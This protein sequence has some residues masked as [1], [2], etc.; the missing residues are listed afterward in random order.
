MWG[1]QAVVHSDAFGNVLKINGTVTQNISLV[2]HQDNGTSTNTQARDTA[3]SGA[4]PASVGAGQSIDEVLEAIVAQGLQ[5][6]GLTGKNVEVSDKYAE[7]VIY[8]DNNDNAMLSYNVGFYYQSDEGDVGKPVYFVEPET[9]KVYFQYDDLQHYQASGPGGNLKTGRY[10]YGSNGL[11]YLD[12]TESNGICTMDN[13]K[14]KTVDLNHGH[15]G[16]DA[17]SF[18]CPTNTH[19]EIN[20]AYS[21]LND[22]H[23]FGV[24]VYDMYSNWYNTAPVPSQLIIR[25][26]YS[27]NHENAFWNGSSA[28]FGD[29]YNRYHPLVGLDVVS[30]EVAHGFTD[31]NSDLIYSGQSGG[32]NEAF[33]DIAGEAAEYFLRGSTDWLVGGDI[34]KGEG[35]ARYFDDPTRDGR[36][37][38]HADNYSDGLNVHYSSGVFNHAF[39]QLANLPNWN[40]RKAFDVFVDANQN[41]WTPSTNFQQGACD[42]LNAADDR[43]YDIT[44]VDL[45]FGVV[46]LYCEN[47]PTRDSDG[48][49]LPDIWEYR[50]GLNHNDATDATL[51]TDNDGI[52]N[53]SEYQLGTFPNDADS[54]DDGLDD[55]D[56]LN[57]HHTNPAIADT[58]SDGLLDGLEINTYNTDPFDSDT[59]D[60]GM[61]DGFEAL[62]GL[63]PHADDSSGDFDGDGLINIEEQQR[64]SNPSVV[65]VIKIDSKDTRRRPVP[66]D[67]F[68]N[69]SYSPDI[70]DETQN[71]SQTIPHVTV[72]ASHYGST[73]IYSFHISGA[74]VKGIFDIDRGDDGSGNFDSDIVIRGDKLDHFIR[75]E[76]SFT[77]SGQGGSISWRD[78]Y[79][80]YTFME[81]GLY[82]ISVNNHGRGRG[83]YNYLLHVSLTLHD[84][85]GDGIGDAWEQQYGLDPNNPADAQLDTDSD[86]LVNLRE[87]QYITSPIDPDSDDDGLKD[88][89]EYDV[90]FTY[91][92]KPDTD[93]DKLTDVEEVLIYHTNP[94]AED[95]DHDSLRDW[96]E[97]FIHGTN[98]ISNDTDN[99]GLPDLYEI[100][101]GFDP[102]ATDNSLLDPD[103]DG[104]ANI[105]EFNAGSKPLNPDTDGDGL[106]DGEEVH[107]HHSSPTKSDTDE[108]GIPDVWEVASGLNP[109]VND[110]ELDND[111]DG[112]T[113]LEEYQNQTDLNNAQS[114]PKPKYRAYVTNYSGDLF[115]LD[116][117]EKTYKKIGRLGYDGRFGSIAVSPKGELYAADAYYK[118][119]YVINPY[120]ATATLIGSLQTERALSY[121]ITFDDKGDL[122]LATSLVTKG[123][124]SSLYKVNPKTAATELIGHIDTNDTYDLAWDGE[125]LWAVGYLFSETMGIANIDRTTA[126]A[127]KLGNNNGGLLSLAADDDR[128]LWGVRGDGQVYTID[129]QTFEYNYEFTTV[130]GAISLAMY[131]E[132]IDGDRDG[133]FDTW[134]RI[135]GLNEFDDSDANK[136]ADNDGLSN[137]QEFTLK[138]DPNNP[139]TD[140]DGLID[141]IDPF[142]RDKTEWIDTDQD[143]IANHLDPDDDNDGIV[144]T[145]DAF[146]LDPTEYQDHDYDGI[147][148]N[149]DSDDDGDNVPDS[150][151]DFP[152]DG[153]EWLDTDRDGVGNNADPDDDN[154]GVADGA[155]AFPL[156]GNE[157]IDSDGDGVG[158]NADKDDDNDGVPDINDSFPLDGSESI[159]S[160]GDGVGNNADTDDDND[161][162]VDSED[163]FPLDKRE[164][165]D[166]DNDGIGNNADTDDDNDGAS[167]AKELEIGSEPLVADTDGDGLLDGRELQ[168]GTSPLLF[169]TDGD[170]LSDGFEVSYGLDP[171]VA[172]SGSSKETDSDEDGLTDY[173]EMVAGTHP[174]KADSDEDGLSDGAEVNDYGTNPLLA[175][176]D[177]DGLGD[178]AELQVHHSNPLK[179]DSDDDQMPDGWE[180]KFGL[181]VNTDDS[182]ADNDGDGRD[183]LT[184]F[185]EFTHPLV[186]EI[187]DLEAN[188]SIAQAQSVDSGFNLAYS[189]DIG[190]MTQN[191]SEVLPHA[192]V[193]G[194]GNGKA[195]VDVYR[196]TV[197][198]ASSKVILDM[199]R[200]LGS[201]VFFDGYIELLDS[202]GKVI[203]A[204][205]D[206]NWYQY[207]QGGSFSEVD[208]YLELTI[209]APGT[210]YVRVSGYTNGFI[211]DGSRYR[212][213]ISVENA[214][215]VI[216]AAAQGQ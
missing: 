6:E 153:S 12:V 207:G 88:G 28:T 110:A 43:N 168:L 141:S 38:G 82:Q 100:E 27:S 133:M 148:N 186:A 132:N 201:N 127:T 107:I 78:S 140:E 29:G 135:Y 15:F 56:E 185:K 53:L 81:D 146:P 215:L 76:N 55:G 114:L 125:K 118:R 192:S 96:A 106:K 200:G 79:L 20:G 205:D 203:Y 75:G 197:S 172:Q 13:S 202:D 142:P 211:P 216:S 156:D 113:N 19:K 102:I 124:G 25:A 151:D 213:H 134:E 83:I 105:D 209:E 36:S 22:A 175:D 1:R 35:A 195:D 178:K 66:L 42:A 65:D 74:P 145:A 163:A 164:W 33:S 177:Q 162:V 26:H 37:I 57:V 112:W 5:A 98:P 92:L 161:G 167:D 198:Q 68:F 48:D 70:G 34:T 85:D 77:K 174:N 67:G 171:L 89:E 158:N 212:L 150:I 104:L 10:E 59:D 103:G 32:I 54:D 4:E 169:D 189:P 14:V 21:P 11:A 170:E 193:Y 101:Q 173:D 61:L 84:S 18:T 149:A 60:D 131:K 46:G 128:N 194:A 41:Y 179:P 210:Y 116:F 147:G 31:H 2:I 108:D 72:V 137:L 129:R 64:G 144:D 123:I 139:D 143:G 90:Y 97:I 214:P 183:N 51:D 115:W 160:D 191:T 62:N 184:E 80:E 155:D 208:S 23:F 176:S 204:N 8:V 58:D 188:D 3:V 30:H 182:L 69:L 73:D 45:A 16:H 157:S 63:D 17:Y 190:D 94:K 39:Y 47:Y 199:D 24:A 40:V 87:F 130:E 7:Q 187:V 180:V 50:Y 119:L 126:Q 91:P 120:N 99:D 159:D 122:Y 9:L 121:G 196:F 52:I 95:S 93:V 181:A 49:G 111:W 154:D 71:T 44:A 166:S 117:R 138:T 136:D 109:Q 206:A 86:G 165:Q 152:L